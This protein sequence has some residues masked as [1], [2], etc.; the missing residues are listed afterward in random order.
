MTD[1]QTARFTAAF[2]GKWR[3]NTRMSK[4]SPGQSVY[5]Q[6]QRLMVIDHELVYQL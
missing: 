4:L 3:G 2:V 5:D 1:E 6:F